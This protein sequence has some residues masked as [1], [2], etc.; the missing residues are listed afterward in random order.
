MLRPF[1]PFIAR[2]FSLYWRNKL[3][4]WFPINA[5]R[6]LRRIVHV[7]DEASNTIFSEKKAELEETSATVGT[8]TTKNSGDQ[9]RGKD[10]MTML[11]ASCLSK[12]L[13]ILRQ[14]AL[15]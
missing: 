7:M 3:V 15:F 11:R 6:D 1:V 14:V 2:H 8:G 13:T 10:M 4:D 9:T 5:L 12:Y